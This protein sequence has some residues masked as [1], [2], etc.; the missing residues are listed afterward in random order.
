MIF[1]CFEIVLTQFRLRFTEVYQF[2][3]TMYNLHY[4]NN[5]EMRFAFR[6]IITI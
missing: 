5:L 2:T 6:G 4:I 3:C 1:A